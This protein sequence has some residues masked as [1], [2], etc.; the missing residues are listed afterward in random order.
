MKYTVIFEHT[1]TNMCGLCV[2]KFL[3]INKLDAIIS[4]IYFGRNLY[5]FR[6]VSL[7]IVR[8]FPLYTQQWFM[9][10]KLYDIYHCCVYSEKLFLVMDRGT[11][12][13]M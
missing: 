12:Q 10:E 8:S 2:N 4:Q 13:N 9:S 7:S 1:F 11:V 6:T 5:M 3:I